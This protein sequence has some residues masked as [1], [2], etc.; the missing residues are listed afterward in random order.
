MRVLVVPG[1]ARSEVVG[2]HGDRIRV[3]VAAPPEKGRANRELCRLL[4]RHFQAAEAEL[5]SGA[6]SRRKVVLVRDPAR[7][8][9]MIR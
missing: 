1:A 6:G 5:V 9:G 4:K 2:R 7:N 8:L 3:R